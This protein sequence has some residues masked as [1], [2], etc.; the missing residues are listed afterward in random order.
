MEVSFFLNGQSVDASLPMNEG[1]E[2]HPLSL[3]VDLQIL[4]SI[5]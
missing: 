2:Q 5:G 3:R 1:D 4:E